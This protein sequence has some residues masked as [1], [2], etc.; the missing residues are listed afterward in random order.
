MHAKYTTITESAECVAKYSL[1]K[2]VYGNTKQKD[3]SARNEGTCVLV[4][5]EALSVEQVGAGTF[6]VYIA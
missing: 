1:M 5:V 4:V 6:H 3:V 2:K